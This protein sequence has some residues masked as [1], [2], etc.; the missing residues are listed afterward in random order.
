MKVNIAATDILINE[1]NILGGN[2]EFVSNSSSLHNLTNIEFIQDLYNLVMDSIENNLKN[3]ENEFN[4]SLE[5]PEETYI[6]RYELL[7]YLGKKKK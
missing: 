7:E 2:L 6:F 1:K 5:V 3:I 4:Q